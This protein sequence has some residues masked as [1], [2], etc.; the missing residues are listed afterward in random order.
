MA[1][2]A[3]CIWFWC[4]TPRKENIV[5]SFSASDCNMM[6]RSARKVGLFFVPIRNDSIFLIMIDC[7]ISKQKLSRTRKYLVWSYSLWKQ[8]GE[9]W[10]LGVCER[11]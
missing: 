10:H 6:N 3:L 11:S 7:R 5:L 1:I 4:G 9:P 2:V 8:Q